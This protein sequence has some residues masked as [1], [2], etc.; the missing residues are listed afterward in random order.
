[1]PIL[2]T[3]IDVEA[4]RLRASL[5]LDRP[6]IEST[7]DQHTRHL[8]FVNPFSQP[9]G[10][11]LKLHAPKGWT[12]TPPSYS[13]TLNPGESFDHDLT[14]EFPYNTVAGV[15]TLQADFSV[16][17]DRHFT[18]SEP[19][20]VTVGLSD[21]GTQ[22][23]AFRDGDDVVVQQMI[24]NYGDKPINY[25]NFAAYPRRPRIERLVSTLR[26]GQTVVKKFRF[27]QVPPGETAKIRIGLKELDGNR[28]LNDEVEIK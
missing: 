4:A 10:G 17:A 3:G 13:F 26:P 20:S 28:I 7:F 2:L 9:I 22:C 23:M 25:T 11:T 14:I 6:L 24:S 16:Q 21:L 27:T 19:L 1:M 12:L 5:V 15:Q 18:F 8:H